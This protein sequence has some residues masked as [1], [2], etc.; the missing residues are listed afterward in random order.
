MSS[1]PESTTE[2]DTPTES[3]AH[4]EEDPPE[5]D[6][7]GKKGKLWLGEERP[8]TAD[9]WE[10]LRASFD[11]SA[12]V[13]DS[14][15]VGRTPAVLAGETDIARA[16]VDTRLRAEV[17]R[18]RLDWVIGPERHS[19]RLEPGPQKGGKHLLFCHLQVGD[20]TRTGIGTGSRL[21]GARRSALAEAAAAFGIGASGQIAGPVAAEKERRNYVPDSVLDA[22]EQQEGP[23][24]WAP[25]GEP[26]EDASPADAAA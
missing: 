16:V 18:D 20:A 9:E 26:P 25:G 17:V 6:F 5:A 21:Q 10:L 1:T 4:G 11:R 24:F 23:S 19:Y 8:L 3:D 14:R 12:Y 15:A 2:D 13:I 7:P 22:L